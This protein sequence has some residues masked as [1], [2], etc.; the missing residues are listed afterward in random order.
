MERIADSVTLPDWTVAARLKEMGRP[1]TWERRRKAPKPVV[2]T[3]PK[4]LVDPSTHCKA[5]I[6]AYLKEKTRATVRE[7]IPVIGLSKEHIRNTLLSNP[8]IFR[9]GK[10]ERR[11]QGRRAVVWG[12]KP[13]AA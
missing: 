5:K 10:K 6:I 11:P 1:V 2:V 3:P 4:R 7:L 13:G 9:A 12:L 8:N